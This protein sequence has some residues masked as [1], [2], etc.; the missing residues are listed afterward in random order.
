MSGSWNPVGKPRKIKKPKITGN[1]IEVKN[2]NLYVVPLNRKGKKMWE[3]ARNLGPAPQNI[4]EVVSTV[5]MP[6]SE[7]QYAEE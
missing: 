7:E 1:T 3:M 2:G 5:E 6:D 4:P